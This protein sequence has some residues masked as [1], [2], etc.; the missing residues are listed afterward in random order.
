MKRIICGFLIF[1]LCIA[2]TACE[3]NTDEVS[4]PPSVSM[5]KTE[6][7]VEEKQINLPGT[8]TP[9]Q[10]LGDGFLINYR[11]PNSH[12]EYLCFLDASSNIVWKHE[13]LEIDSFSLFEEDKIFLRNSNGLFF[14]NP[15]GSVLWKNAELLGDPSF[16]MD[17]AFSDHMGGVYLLGANLKNDKQCTIVHINQNGQIVSQKPFEELKLFQAHSVW[18]KADGGYWLLGSLISDSSTRYLL[19]YMDSNLN[20]IKTFS[21]MKNHYSP[22]ILFSPES[23]QI[24]IYG[25]ASN[26]AHENFGFLYELDY[27]FQQKQY[28]RYD[29]CYPENVVRLKDGRWLVSYGSNNL[30]KLFSA[31]WTDFSTININYWPDRILALDDGGFA[32]TGNVLSP[33]QSPYTPYLSSVRGKYDLIY[34]RFDAE[35]NLK[36]RKS[37]LSQ[38]SN[39]GYMYYPFIDSSGNIFLF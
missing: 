31:D 7:T 38:N 37:Y 21:L 10:K 1:A 8:A 33:G 12:D 25:Q 17:V 9:M 5:E 18:P 23:D 20:V 24:I 34:E 11:E 3:K 6:E 13:I 16:Y 39:D 14:L 36:F 35:C 29:D 28:V 4:P 32:I 26:D 30:L 2:L 27:N 15:D 22:Q 19:S